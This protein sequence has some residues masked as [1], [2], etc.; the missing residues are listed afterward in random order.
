MTPR[1]LSTALAITLAVAVV[2]GTAAAAVDYQLNREPPPL[3]E[4]AHTA[5]VP[6]A[7]AGTPPD[8]GLPADGK[9]EAAIAAPEL[10]VFAASP[11][12]HPVSIASVAKV[13]TALQVLADHP[14]KPGEPGPSLTV[15]AAD[16]RAYQAAVANEES[17]V[18]VAA[19]EQLT[20]YQ[21]LQG[22]LIPSANNFARM[23]AAWDAGT[24]PAFVQRMNDRAARF[25]LRQTVFADPAG[26]DGSTRSVPTDLALLALQAIQD[27]VLMEIAGQARA[28]LP[29]AGTVYNVDHVLGEQGI[30]GI[31]TGSGPEFGGNFM[32]AATVQPTGGKNVTLVGAVLG[33]PTLDDAFL[34]TEKLIGNAV[35]GLTYT[36]VLEAGTR[37]GTVASAWGAETPVV[38]SQAVFAV[39]W[40]GTRLSARVDGPGEPLRAPLAAGSGA[41]RLELRVGAQVVVAGLSTER[42]IVG[43]GRAWRLLRTR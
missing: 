22:L 37:M 7:I 33:M 18:A 40:P 43:P 2:A 4:A 9:A 13:M 21:V 3:T 32:F 20:E 19:G 10:G 1:R 36:K 42:S 8:I 23:V 12:E 27:P 30:I 34:L 5:A 26:V 6:R 25:Q 31:K 41:G 17:A 24:V 16:V 29:V 15:T 11:N 14:L 28:S 35:R 39:G 38:L